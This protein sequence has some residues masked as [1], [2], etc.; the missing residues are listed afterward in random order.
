MK[1]NIYPGVKRYYFSEDGV[2]NN[3]GAI[4]GRTVFTCV[5]L[6]DRNAKRKFDNW[7]KLQ[8]V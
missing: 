1:K 7:K 5:A 3:R 8:Q 6:N 2:F 4:W